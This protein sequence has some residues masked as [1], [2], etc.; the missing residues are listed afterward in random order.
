MPRRTM[1]DAERAAL[2]AGR[3]PAPPAPPGN[4]LA[5]KHGG[6]ATIAADR[7][8]VKQRE[9]FDA[10]AA[11]APL[12]DSA[13]ELP[14][15]D[16]VAVHEL[17]EALCRLEDVRAHLRDTGWIDQKTGEPR[18]AVLAVEDRLAG[19]VG[20]LLDV[21]GMT[22]KSRAALGLDLARTVD[23]ATAMSEPDPALRRSLMHQAGAPIDDVEAEGV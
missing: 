9:V 20:R 17:A 3:R 21:L 5:R 7:L 18:T 6:W 13:G 2:D 12:R 11:D 15:H 23:L 4:Q 10:L 14:R 22:P 16:A 8:D 1:T 19:R